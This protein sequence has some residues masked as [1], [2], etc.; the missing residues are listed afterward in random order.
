MTHG[1]DML[2]RDIRQSGDGDKYGHAMGWAFALGECLAVMR[3][4]YGED[5]AGEVSAAFAAAQ[6][7]PA[8]SGIL[9]EIESM[10]DQVEEIE[11][12]VVASAV[13]HGEADEDDVLYLFRVMCRYSD[14]LDRAGLSY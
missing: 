8:A 11:R 12:H 13:F 6:F 4:D 2:R 14:V 1:V 9:R 7:R 10:A 3:Y 5:F